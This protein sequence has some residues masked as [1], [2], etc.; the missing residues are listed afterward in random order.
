[1]L[2]SFLNRVIDERKVNS[3]YICLIA[4]STWLS[5]VALALTLGPQYMLDELL[6]RLVVRA[7]PVDL[8]ACLA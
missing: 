3:V 2:T 7:F 4:L 6:E 1:M 8:P 5:S